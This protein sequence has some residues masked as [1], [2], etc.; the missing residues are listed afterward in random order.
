M[1]ISPADMR[2][3]IRG[4]SDRCHR[5]GSFTHDLAHIVWCHICHGC[6]HLF[7]EASFTVDGNGTESSLKH[8]PGTARQFRCC[9]LNILLTQKQC[10][11]R[12]ILDSFLLLPDFVCAQF[13]CFR[14]F[15]QCSP[16]TRVCLCVR[17]TRRRSR[18]CRRGERFTEPGGRHPTLKHCEW[19]SLTEMRLVCSPGPCEGGS[20]SMV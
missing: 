1:W 4:L 12:Y 10:L 14:W 6:C 8:M 20:V 15:N 13:A 19:N 16:V 11:T 9:R 3:A 18:L 2:L 5:F 17:S 7:V